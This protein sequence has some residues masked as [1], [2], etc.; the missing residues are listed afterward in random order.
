VDFIVHVVAQNTVVL[1]EF[2]VVKIDIDV[3]SAPKLVL[4]ESNLLSK[5]ERVV[6]LV[7]DLESCL[8]CG[9]L[10]NCGAKLFSYPRTKRSSCVISSNPSLRFVELVVSFDYA[11]N[12]KRLSNILVYEEE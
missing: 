2:K 3:G 5:A 9:V 11:D 4:S 6:L 12:F 1:G 7:A 10:I 8:L